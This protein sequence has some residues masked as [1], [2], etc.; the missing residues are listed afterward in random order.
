MLHLYDDIYLEV[1]GTK[2]HDTV[3]LVELEIQWIEVF[4]KAK[5]ILKKTF[6]FYETRFELNLNMTL[7]EP[8]GYRCFPTQRNR[9]ILFY[10]IKSQVTEKTRLKIMSPN[11]RS[12]K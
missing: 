11:C 3:E 10:G 4:A 8:N 9:Y 2:F 6:R 12:K 5:I 1:M 7:L